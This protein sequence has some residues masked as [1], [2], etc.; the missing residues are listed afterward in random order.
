MKFTKM[1]GA[2]ND[3]IYVDCFCQKIEN[4]SEIAK[5]VSDRHFGIGSDGL[6]CVCP[7]EV[8]DCK[9]DMYNIDGSQGKMCGN[10]VR[11]V[12]KFVYDNGIAVKD[13]ITVETLSGIKKIHVYH[14]NGKVYKATVNMGQ[15]I[16]QA[17]KIPVNV[18]NGEEI[19]YHLCVDGKDYTV[20]YVSMGNPHCVTYV[21][22]DVDLKKMDLE[23]IGPSFEK[24][25]KHPEGINT[26]F[27]K[28]IDKNTLQMRVY[29]RGSGETLACGT[30]ACASVVSSVLNGIVNRNE[31]ITVELLGGN[32]EIIWSDDG[33]VYMTGPAATVCTGDI[34]I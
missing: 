26:E 6:I 12:A 30:G 18:P 10:G 1:H 20:T 29:E 28:V 17:D 22:D 4:R 25:E 13:D 7:S 5:K 21:D 8:A 11:C 27:I 33:N 24:H 31:L 23:K 16:L 34:E 14:E 9:M 19:G 2:G 3:Y 15:P 32:L